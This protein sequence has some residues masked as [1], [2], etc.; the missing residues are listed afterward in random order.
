MTMLARMLSPWF[1]RD[2][3]WTR[4]RLS[5]Y[6]DDEL[7]PRGRGRVDR[8]VHLCPSCHRLLAGLRRTLEGLHGLARRP[9]PQ[10]AV[11]DAVIQRLRSDDRRGT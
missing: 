4:K 10:I 9:G 3:M 2:H 1:M 5:E 7:D 11:A 6:L 8:H